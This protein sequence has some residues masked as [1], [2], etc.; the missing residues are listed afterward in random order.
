MSELD[1]PEPEA[2]DEHRPDADEHDADP[3]KAEEKRDLGR[4]AT[5]S[6]CF[7]GNAGDRALV[8]GHVVL[9]APIVRVG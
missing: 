3:G 6:R 2:E 1:E 8:D 7:E 4:V 5:T 9:D